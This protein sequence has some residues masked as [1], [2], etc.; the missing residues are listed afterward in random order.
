MKKLLLYV[1]FSSVIASGLF[2]QNLEMAPDISAKTPLYI[3]IS[4]PNANLPTEP[5]T[6]GSIIM[7]N[8]HSHQLYNSFGTQRSGFQPPNEEWKKIQQYFAGGVLI[9][10]GVGCVYGIIKTRSAN[11]EALFGVTK[12]LSILVYGFEGGLI[13]G[14]VGVVAYFVFGQSESDLDFQH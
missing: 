12:P 2:G 8:P 11:D 10:F 9:G 3:L 1:C 13:G 4:N 6:Q 5:S 7:R 14:A